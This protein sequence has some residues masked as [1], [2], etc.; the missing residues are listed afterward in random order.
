MTHWLVHSVV[1]LN[2]ENLR[3]RRIEKDYFPLSV[4]GYKTVVN[5]V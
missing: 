5:R 3:R 1:S 2:A 4:N